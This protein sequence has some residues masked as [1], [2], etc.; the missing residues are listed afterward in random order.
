MNSITKLLVAMFLAASAAVVPARVWADDVDDA[1]EI[2]KHGEVNSAKEFVIYGEMNPT[3][4]IKEIGIM[5][6]WKDIQAFNT[7]DAFAGKAMMAVMDGQA[8]VLTLPA[9]ASTGYGPVDIATALKKM[10]A[11]YN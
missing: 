1:I 8:D 2:L 5:T 7:G 6:D 3:K 4:E 11:V 9:V 10:Q